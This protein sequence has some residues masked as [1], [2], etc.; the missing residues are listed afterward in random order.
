MILLNFKIGDVVSRKSY[1]NDIIFEI[2]DID[3][4][5]DIVTLKG[6]DLRLYAD[7]SMEDLKHEEKELDT[8]REDRKIITDNI[9]S[10]ELNRDKF[11]FLP[12]VIVHL[13][14][15]PF[16]LERCINFYH[17]LNV[18]AYGFV[19]KEDEL[20]SRIEN[21]LEQYNPDILVITGHDAYY[22]K[23][24]DTSNL[25]N[26]QNSK[27]FVKAVKTARKYEKDQN[28]LII[29]SG[30]CQSNYE[31]L[32]RAGANFASSPKRINIHALDPAI[33]AS[34]VALSVNSKSIDLLS[35][36]EKTKYGSDGIGG[37]ITNG[38]MF[39][40]YPR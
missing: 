35:V 31:E 24:N 6:V 37:I 34:S 8:V 28:K 32:I 23:K 16:F 25:D 36:I 22:K 40:G 26:Y 19:V 13:D 14:S 29:I 18:K 3:R 27:N 33:I 20:S 15:D 5:N 2:V 17:D 11:F 7:C 30:A 10:I 21:Y 12:G 39:V 9:K 1:N 38:T 4:D